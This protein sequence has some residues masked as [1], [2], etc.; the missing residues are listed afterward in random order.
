VQGNVGIAQKIRGGPGV[1]ARQSRANATAYENAVA[2][3]EKTWKRLAE[4]RKNS[5]SDLLNG[6]RIGKPI[7]KDGELV[8]PES[9]ERP[10]RR[11][12]AFQPSGKRDK[13]IAAGQVTERMVD[14]PE[15]VNVDQQHRDR[16]VRLFERSLQAEPQQLAVRQPGE[17]TPGWIYADAVGSAADCGPSGGQNAT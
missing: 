15:T 14:L 11:Y 7:Q 8:A 17:R 13:R 9:S 10:V 5:D 6:R 2:A 16:P 3:A 4:N 1:R 12:G